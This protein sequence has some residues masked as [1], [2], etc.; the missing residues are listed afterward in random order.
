MKEIIVKIPDENSDLATQ[1]LEKLGAEVKETKISVKKINA[2]KIKVL[3]KR[4][5]PEKISPTYLFGKWKNLDVD[6]KKLREEAWDRSH[7]YL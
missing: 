2:K 5:V 6:S 3:K 1:L 7:K 4:K